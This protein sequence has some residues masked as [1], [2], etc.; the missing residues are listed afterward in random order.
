MIGGLDNG[1]LFDLE[2]SGEIQ[3]SINNAAVSGYIENL[4]QGGVLGGLIGRANVG[5]EIAF[6]GET[7]VETYLLKGDTRA[8]LIGEGNQAL[9]YTTNTFTLFADGSVRG[10][11][12]DLGMDISKG[13][14]VFGILDLYAPVS[15]LGAEAEPYRISCANDLMLLAAAV[16]TE[17]AGPSCFS[18]PDG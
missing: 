1:G 13:C 3:L 6:G 8:L 5:C 11:G 14:A 9:A 15:G 16:N 2:N 7:A 12:E 17:T 4:C 10:L 18:Y